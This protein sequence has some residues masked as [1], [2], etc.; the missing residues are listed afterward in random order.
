MARSLTWAEHISEA[1]R[2]NAARHAEVR[3]ADV[4]NANVA[5]SNT[6]GQ[7]IRGLISC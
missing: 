1:S 4:A 6:E 3:N 2:S 5:T 7:L